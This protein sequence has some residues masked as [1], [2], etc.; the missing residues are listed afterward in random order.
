VHGLQNVFA[1]DQLVD[2]A[3]Q[4][5]AGIDGVD[6]VHKAGHGAGPAVQ[7][8]GGHGQVD[9][10][11][12][13]KELAG[14]RKDHGAVELAAA[15]SRF[16]EAGGDAVNAVH[17]DDPVGQQVE[18]VAQIVPE[19]GLLP[20]HQDGGGVHLLE[21]PPGGV[22]I[23]NPVGADDAQVVVIHMAQVGHRD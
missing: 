6:V 11:A 10:V 18:A 13:A 5:T 14:L 12:G 17:L 9:D 4:H 7:Q 22:G 21:Q 16:K 15:V 1:H 23:V 19:R 20:Q 3:P 8:G 2:G